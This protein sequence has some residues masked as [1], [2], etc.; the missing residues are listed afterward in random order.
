MTTEEIEDILKR[1]QEGRCTPAEQLWVHSWN[2]ELHAKATKNPPPAIQDLEVIEE[3]IWSKVTKVKRRPVYYWPVAAAIALII[4]AA[5]GYFLYIA[6]TPQKIVT[7]TTPPHDLPAGSNKAILT[8]AN[9][10]RLVL[11]DLKNGQIALQNGIKIIKDKSGQIIYTVAA[12]TP[13]GTDGEDREAGPAFNTITT[14]NGGQYLV[15]LPDG[16]RAYLNAASSLK[17]PIRFD[18]TERRVILSGEA[19][20]E[21][22]KDRSHPFIV[23]SSMQSVKV[24]GTH[25]NVSCYPDEPIKTTLA[26]GKVEITMATTAKKAIL[27]PGEQSIV[28]NTTLQVNP[29]N[30]DD[31]IAW[32]DGLFVFTQTDI[33]AVLKQIARW[34]N[35]EVDYANLPDQKFEG[36]ISRKVGLLQVLKAIE[37]GSDVKLTIEGR[38]IMRK[39]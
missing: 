14:P 12:L 5:T 4:T 34:Y 22:S 9:G 36:E 18:G 29:V 13:L 38:R 37:Q 25:F 20:F 30:P 3:R 15:I 8:L 27:K 7:Y 32:K 10:K 6:N 33:K 17:Y 31:V 19:Y 26:E 28:N 39:L 1:Y 24:L 11:E 2:N 23:A 16:S 35:V 21:I